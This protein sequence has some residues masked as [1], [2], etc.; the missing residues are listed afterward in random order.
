MLLHLAL[1][2]TVIID[3]SKDE[4]SASSQDELALVEGAKQLGYEFLKKSAD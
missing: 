3:I 2:H 1:C 4:Y